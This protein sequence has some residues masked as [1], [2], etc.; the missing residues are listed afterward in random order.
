MKKPLIY[1]FSEAYFLIRK[2]VL[3]SDLTTGILFIRGAESLRWNIGRMLVA[4]NYYRAK[5]NT[6]AYKDFLGKHRAF[7]GSIAS[8]PIMDKENYIKA[9]SLEDKCRGGKIPGQGVVID[10]SSGSTGLPSN[11]VRGEKERSENKKML[12]FGLNRLLGK[13]EKFIVNAFAMGPWATGVNVTMSFAGS[14]IVKSLGPDVKKIENTLLYFGTRHHYVIMGYPPFLK[15][16]VD[17]EY[18]AWQEYN[19]SF[20][21]GGEGMSEA[22]RDYFLEKGISR[23]YG[24]LGA[25]DLELNLASENDFTIALRK[26]IATNK[27]LAGRILKKSGALPMIF[28]Y[29]PMDFYVESNASGEL[30][31][32]LC[33]KNY[34]CPKIRYNIHDTGH[35]L[36]MPDLLSILKDLGIG[37]ADLKLPA[38]DLPLLFHY[39]RS[40]MS[41]AYFGCKISPADIQES[42]F[43]IAALANAVNSFT[44]YTYEDTD[45]NKNLRICFE[46]KEHLEPATWEADHAAAIQHMLPTLAAVNQDFRESIKMLP[47]GSG[48]QLVFYTLGSGPFQ[49]ADIRI[50][51]RYISN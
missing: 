8:L 24:S 46:L 5:K 18:I 49:D 32:S 45:L 12:V 33:R 17:S 1:I 25:S 21:F 31:F 51:A 28:Q 16:L 41:V 35:V 13:E 10:E 7:N 15:S 26:L 30:L 19:I 4:Y 38:T 48:P 40:D 29:N 6:P 3:R 50:K 36:R 34:V 27:E 42:I 39:G 47:A 22:M 43:R 11:W 23:V 9:Y 37:D 44:L 20:I 2:L 14:A